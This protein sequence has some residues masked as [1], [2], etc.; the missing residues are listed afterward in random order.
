MLNGYLMGIPPQEVRH[1][2]DWDEMR[3][4][5]EV[6]RIIVRREQMWV[7]LWVFG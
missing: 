2:E 4:E 3:G 6:I 5:N 1:R 7:V